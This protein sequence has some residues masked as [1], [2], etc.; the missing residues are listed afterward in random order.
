MLLF[1]WPASFFSAFRIAALSAVPQWHF[2]VTL[3]QSGRRL[4]KKRRF[5]EKRHGTW[6]RWLAAISPFPC[7]LS[8][9]FLLL[10]MRAVRPD[11]RVR[12]LVIGAGVVRDDSMSGYSAA[13]TRC[14]WGWLVGLE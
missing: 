11:V 14:R 2:G 5:A 6:C 13:E 9:C 12:H 10:Y 7:S 1:D 8:R 4:L 3:P